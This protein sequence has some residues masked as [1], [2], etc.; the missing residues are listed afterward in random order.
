VKKIIHIV[1]IINRLITGVIIN[2]PRLN[3]TPAL[4]RDSDAKLPIF[5]ITNLKAAVV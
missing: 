5:K 1:S 4:T 2:P 3:A